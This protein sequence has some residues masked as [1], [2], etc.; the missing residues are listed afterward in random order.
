MSAR[1]VAVIVGGDHI[2]GDRG[3]KTM[4]VQLSK[5]PVVFIAIRASQVGWHTAA[6]GPLAIRG[7]GATASASRSHQRAVGRWL[8][9]ASSSTPTTIAEMMQA[10]MSGTPN[11]AK[12]A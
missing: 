4:G 6:L 7:N 3:P 8:G 5:A 10:M 9:Y 2:P 11:R 12:V 1:V